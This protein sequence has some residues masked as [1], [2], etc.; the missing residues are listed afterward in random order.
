MDP[1]RLAPLLPLALALL[2][3]GCEARGEAQDRSRADGESRPVL[4][5]VIAYERAAPDR[6]FVGTV[7]PRVESDLGFR[8]AGK[9][10]KRLVNV[11]DVVV[12]GTPLATLDEVDLRLQMEQAG[13]EVATARVGVTQADADLSRTTS[14]ADKGWTA[15]A[16]VD[17]QRATTEEARSRLLRAE[18]AL[19]LARNAFAY[20][21]LPADADGAV[22][23]T[24]VEPGQVVTA[25]QL[26]IRLA[27]TAE[28][29]AVVAIPEAFVARA[30]DG[31]AR[32]TLWSSA[33][34]VFPASLRELAPAADPA[35]RTFLARFT[36][37][38][39]DDR[40]RLGMTATVTLT[41]PD[42]DTVARVPMTAVYDEGHGPSLWSVEEGG[43][44][45]LRPVAV[46]RYEGSDA[47]VRGVPAGT[48]IVSLGVHK[49][50]PTQR[51]R[52]VDALA[53]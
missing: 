13:A 29:E 14:L 15:Q 31:A 9:V 49:L 1:I 27:H 4:V 38:G 10:A 25:G 48:R 42:A 20:A 30:R 19:D 47:L 5:Q 32:V 8:I 16:T 45:T 2:L 24:A 11:G 26:A 46:V 53:F 3:A 12:A 28:R 40:V 39:A 7:R 21:V 51:V 22:T 41:A 34:A 52:V 36:I 17:R 37:A 18:R 33:G 23:A 44:L 35:T 43:R 6:S 50:D